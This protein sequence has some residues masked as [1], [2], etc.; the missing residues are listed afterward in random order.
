MPVGVGIG[1]A[2]VVGL[3]IESTS[4]EYQAPEKFFPIRSENFQ[5]TQDTVWRRVIRG[6]SDVI[7]AVPGDG[8]VEGSLDMEAL[9]DVLPYFLRIARGDLTQTGTDP[10][11]YEFVPNSAAEPA[12]TA[13]ITVVRNGIVFGY[14]G[15]VVGSFS[16]SVDDGQLVVDL[17]M[18]GRIGK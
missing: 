5:W 6:T 15:C 8:H 18:L 16:F 1:A 10:V 12:Q 14:T 2:G 13:S 3:A 9:D 4:G 11:N 7:G 17:S